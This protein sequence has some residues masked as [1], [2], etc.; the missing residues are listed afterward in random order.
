[1][2]ALWVETLGAYMDPKVEK[3]A[4]V[5]VHYSLG[6]RRG[7]LVRIGGPA[8]AASHIIAAYTEALRVG[9]HPTVR[10]SV[11][12]LEEAYYKSATDEQLRF[13]S[14][15]DIHETETLDAELRFLGSYN[16][17]ALTRVDP[18]RMAVR[19]E[20]TRDLTRRFLE[21]A[22]RDELRWCLTQAPTQSDAQEAE[23][24][25]GEYEEFVY[26]AG[27]LDQDDPV[28]TWREVE[29]EQ[30]GIIA[31]LEKVKTLRIVGPDTDLTVSVAG[32]RW[33]NAAGKHNFPDGEVFTG[34][35]EDATRGTVRFTFPAIYGGREVTDVR[36][37][38]KDG[39]VT[40]ATAGKGETFLRAMLDID[41]GA[42]RLGEFAFGLNY[43]IRQFTRNILFDEKIGGTVHMA[44]GA[45]YP[46]TGG[47]NSSGLHWDMILDLRVD[48]AE[49]YA[50]DELLY[51]NGQFLSR[52]RL[53]TGSFQDTSRRAPA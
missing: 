33:M 20:A 1:M 41:A 19:R 45:A 25:L 14:P 27:H 12:G 42:R 6:L 34:P 18:A 26:T 35:V 10:V 2:P 46:E 44:L 53:R 32:R 4:R 49:V 5:L 29:R 38:F 40:D 52:P 22:G 24:S 28:T 21:R 16:T 23:M 11:D 8:L 30:A 9:A 31:R 50:D 17:R 15:L 37:T 39:R 51:K 43:D 48:G 47:T 3:L 36:L 7:Q 13:V